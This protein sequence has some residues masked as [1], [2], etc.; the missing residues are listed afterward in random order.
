MPIDAVSLHAA[1]LFDACGPVLLVG[2][3]RPDLVPVLAA[4]AQDVVL[5]VPPWREA[6][7]VH[8]LGAAGVPV[9][10]AAS[11]D[12]GLPVGLPLAS[13]LLLVDELPDV[14]PLLL[15][16]RA[17]AA[18]AHDGMVC[19]DLAAGAVHEGRMRRLVEAG[20]VFE[21]GAG[22]AAWSGPGR[23]ALHGR[24][25][26]PGRDVV[27]VAG[28]LS[29]LTYVLVVGDEEDASVPVADVLL[30]Q[31]HPAEL[32]LIVDPTRA[33]DDDLWGMKSHGL[34]QPAILRPDGD[35]RGAWL[36]EAL[37]HVDTESVCVLEASAGLAP[38]HAL[39][40]TSLLA[41]RED[42]VGVLSSGF[43]SL[44]DGEE[45]LPFDAADFGENL[46]RELWGGT[47]FASAAL[48]LRT[49]AVRAVGG[50]DA[51]LD[52]MAGH[53]LWLRLAE[54]GPFV[55]APLPLWVDSDA[56][57]ERDDGAGRVFEAAHERDAI[58]RLAACWTALP[59]DERRPT[60]L[61]HRA[62]ALSE[63]G[64][65]DRARRDLEAARAGAAPAAFTLTAARDHLRAGDAAAVRAV[66]DA[67]PPA[68]RD[69]VSDWRA[70]AC[71]VDRDPEGALEVL[72]GAEY[73]SAESLVLRL[74]AVADV[75]GADPSVALVLAN[76]VQELLD[77]GDDLLDEDLVTF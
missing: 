41:A 8:D 25:R 53:D 62:L 46:T 51:A 28:E 14:D 21:D 70:A 32:L 22:W 31:T 35:G 2:G 12:D 63:A 73:E 54:R 68:V 44:D 60:A 18:V 50:F 13:T 56:E 69:L 71:M 15:A 48:C 65:V 5:V 45:L 11:G 17:L 30:R 66:L 38:R 39:V 43:M 19:V 36:A 34:T 57:V 75:T 6:G 33:V 55:A 23:V 10:V 49:D 64:L 26:A 16:D 29:P 59:E 4:A 76:L 72:D 52:R 58:G 37:E 27:P 3:G 9:T 42:A 20:V 1:V 40:T 47:P 77:G 24:R 7:L 67:A 61:L 74:F